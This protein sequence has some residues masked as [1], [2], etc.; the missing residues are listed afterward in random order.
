MVFVGLDRSRCFP[1]AR[2]EAT[3]SRQCSAAGLLELGLVEKVGEIG[4][5]VNDAD[6]VGYR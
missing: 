1:L 5:S 4:I 6:E 2:R 3:F